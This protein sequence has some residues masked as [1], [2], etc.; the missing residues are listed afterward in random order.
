MKS[1]TTYL[2]DPVRLAR[3]KRWFYAGLA[4]LAVSEVA[5]PLVF[6]SDPA[7]FW[8]EDLPAWGSLYGL[9]SCVAIIVVSKLLGKLW[10]TRPEN[11]YDS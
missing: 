5:V 4:I 7:H 6:Q 1:L 2:E 9:V 11:Y 3:M 8:F 10:L